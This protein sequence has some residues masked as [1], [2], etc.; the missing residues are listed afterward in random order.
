MGNA[1]RDQRHEPEGT[2]SDDIKPALS[3]EEW[4][5]IHELDLLPSLAEFIAIREVTTPHGL[6]AKCLYGTPQGFT[7][8]DVAMLRVFASPP[9]VP[10]FRP[11]LFLANRISALLPPV[12]P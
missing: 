10:P 7:Q 1:D 11:L 4:D 3:R 2:M 6:A 9:D 5:K 12:T 8:D